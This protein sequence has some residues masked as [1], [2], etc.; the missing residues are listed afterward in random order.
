ML[1]ADTVLIATGMTEDNDMFSEWDKLVPDLRIIGDCERTARIMEA[2]RSGYCA[3]Y[4]I[5]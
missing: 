3:G 5:D 1:P 2:V 4:S